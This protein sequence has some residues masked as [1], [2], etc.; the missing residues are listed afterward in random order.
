[1]GCYNFPGRWNIDPQLREWGGSKSFFECKWKGKFCS[2]NILHIF[3][4][5]ASA[6]HMQH[7][8]FLF[9]LQKCV[10]KEPIKTTMHL[11]YISFVALYVRFYVLSFILYISW[12]DDPHMHT[13]VKRECSY[14]HWAHKFKFA[15]ILYSERCILFFVNQLWQVITKHTVLYSWLFDNNIN[16]R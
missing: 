13:F 14:I 6:M 3:F 16:G 2:V 5:G 15:L 4:Y 7:K 8:M 9:F 10:V 12:F 1:M 11:K